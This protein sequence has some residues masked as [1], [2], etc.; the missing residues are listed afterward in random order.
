MT[1]ENM[2]GFLSIGAL[3]MAS[4]NRSW[5]FH[6]LLSALC[7]LALLPAAGTASS[8]QED[9]PA[10]D[11]VFEALGVSP[12]IA[13]LQEKIRADDRNA[14]GAF[15]AEAAK[16]TT[17]IIEPGAGD[18]HH[19]IVTFVWQAPPATKMVLL[20]STAIRERKFTDG[21]M[22]RLADTDVWYKVLRMRSDLRFTYRFAP[23]PMKISLGS[24]DSFK[25]DPLNPKKFLG[26][27]DAENPGSSVAE[28]SI[29]EL[30][31][32]PPQPWI[33]RKPGV[34]AG[35][36]SME[37]LR[38]E[39]LKNERR[40]WTYLPP[41]YSPK[42]KAYPLLVCFD[43]FGYATATNIPTA[44]ILDNLIA[45]RRIPPI[46]A[47]LVDNPWDVR[48]TELT[49]YHPFVEFLAT[50]LLPGAHKRWNITS[51]PKQTIACGYSAGGLTSS[52][53]ALER[54][55]I[56]GNVLSQSGAYWRGEAG[57]EAHFEWVTAQFR[58]RPKLPIRF[59]LQVGSTEQMSSPNGG[60][61]MLQTHE[62]LRD[63]LSAKGYDFTLTAEPGGHEPIDWRNGLADGLIQLL[64]AK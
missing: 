31:D 14:V 8:K 18:P 3:P 12:A 15:M 46:V 59:V 4:S 10:P 51:D 40:I 5:L 2:T 16:R 48:S 13:A 41:G 36:T 60:P 56:F 62:H 53:V 32:A 44:T 45:A 43:G 34:P 55:D 54:P 29:A 49:N 39:I 17:P 22:T 24:P 50:E 57:D 1:V 9:L 26:E 28:G 64:G 19:V 6:G 33:E 37:R 61:N 42:A 25:F 27:R 23:D 52:Y 47:L 30:P 7:M 35:T 11:S 21:L 63:V 58:Q 20:L 38:S